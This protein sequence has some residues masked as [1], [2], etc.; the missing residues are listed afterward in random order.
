M[1]A[2][3]ELRVFEKDFLTA[4]Q[5]FFKTMLLS[6]TIS[7]VLVPMELPTGQLMPTLI[8]HPDHMERA[9]PFAPYFPLNAAKIVSKLT[10][11]PLGQKIAVV[12]RPCEIRA[13]YELVKL[14]QGST[15][16]L[17]ILS[18]DCLGAF[19]NKTYFDLKDKHKLPSTQTLIYRLLQGE[20]A[21]ESGPGLS[22]ACQACEHPVPENADIAIELLGRD[23]NQSITL[24]GQTEKGIS[25]IK[26]LGLISADASLERDEAV[27]SL[28]ENRVAY[29][30]RMF[31][32]TR[33]VIQGLYKLSLYLSKC[34]N[35]YNCREAC[36]VCY[37]NQCVFLTDTF[38]HDA[39][40]YYS[41]AKRKGAI[42]MPTDTVFFQMT[43][44]AH[45][46]AMC[47]GCGQCSNACPNDIPV[48]EL[49]RLVG[50]NVQK[51]FNYTPGM[52]LEDPPP[53]SLFLEDEFHE[54]EGI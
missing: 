48:M 52:T 43:R 32:E 49:M 29:R 7:A 35:C 31:K 37:C 15:D 47:V 17:V 13:F 46:G 11:K 2:F 21:M 25:L 41:W 39:Y 42:K 5:Q 45:I 38:D 27:S 4:V 16:E 3:V 34:V 20:G 18:M 51:A 12:L 10:R 22:N 36:P 30:D 24:Q 1:A 33:E 26:E 8:T 9:E 19:D 28:I 14:K 44:M 6:E 50:F 54:V 40:Q 23:V 53:M